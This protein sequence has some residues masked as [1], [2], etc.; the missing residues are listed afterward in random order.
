LDIQIGKCAVLSDPFDNTLVI[1][2]ASKG[3]LVTDADGKILGNR[4]EGADS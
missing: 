4:L 1:L 3:W 2:D